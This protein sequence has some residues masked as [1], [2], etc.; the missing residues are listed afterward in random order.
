MITLRPY[1]DEAIAAVLAYWAAGGG[2]PLVDLATGL[3]KSVVIGQLTRGVLERY[4][5]MR[6]LMLVHVRELVEQNFLALKRLWPDAPAGIYSAGL[7]RRDT[8]HRIT[9]ASVQS[10]F[11]RAEALGPRDLVLIDEAQ[12]VPNGG[13]GMY[14]T[15]LEDLREMRP[16]LRGA[17]FTATPFRMDSGRLDDKGALFDETVYSYG[18]RKGI[19]DGYLSPLVSKRGESEID[20]SGVARRGGEFVAGALEEAA[21]DEAVI[22]SAVAE[23]VARGADRRSWL[24]F[25]AGVKNAY[26]VRDVIR[27][28]GVSCETIT[29][30]THPGERARFIADFKAGRIR[31]LTNANVLTTGFDAPAVDMIAM[32]RPTLSTGLFVQ[33]CGRGTR[34]AEGKANCLVLDFAGVV[35]R[36]G[37]VDMVEVLP[38]RKGAPAEPKVGVDDVRAKTCPECD[39]LSGLRAKSCFVCGYEWP[40][41]E[42]TPSHAAVADDVPILSTEAG[43]LST[44]NEQPVLSW[45]A[46]RWTK[47]GAPDSLRV[48]YMAGLQAFNEWV[49]PEHEGFARRKFEKWWREHRGVEPA[50]T[51]VADAIVRF[52]EITRPDIIITRRNGRWHDIVSR[53]L[54]KLEQGEAA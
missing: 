41:V 18:I 11:R 21:S 7:G 49:C 27:S 47:P 14:H 8:H 54:A 50:P 33:M 48:T 22:Q 31:C 39:H 45:S 26:R 52:G 35:R 44:V 46:A 1:Q 23:I 51:S 32:L 9:F 36:H 3:G 30:E 15:L 13:D 4:P 38:K 29:G 34:L 53:R 43:V 12:L 16:D 37:P 40:F 19:E 17:G 6:V 2:N 42:P 10:V 5:D 25:C 24:S 20:V 28:H